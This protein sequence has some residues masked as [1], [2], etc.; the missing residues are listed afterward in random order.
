MVKKKYEKAQ[1]ENPDSSKRE[2]RE[3]APQKIPDENT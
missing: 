1:K 3:L 2:N